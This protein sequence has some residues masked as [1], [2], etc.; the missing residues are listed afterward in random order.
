MSYSDRNSRNC[1]Y[2]RQYFSIVFLLN[3]PPVLVLC[4]CKSY[5]GKNL[6]QE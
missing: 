5:L 1:A 6:L 2:G 4:G 3:A